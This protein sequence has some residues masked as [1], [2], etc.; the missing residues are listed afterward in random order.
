MENTSNI[1]ASEVNKFSSK[2]NE[3][4]DKTGAFKT[5]HDINPVRLSFINDNYPLKGLCVLDIGCGGGILSEA[6]AQKGA[7]VVGL[8][9]S[10]ENIMI[11]SNHAKENKLDINYIVNTAESFSAEHK[12]QF[13]L[14]TC[15]ELLEHVPD[16]LSIIKSCSE[17]VRPGGHVMLSTINRNLKAYMFGVVAAEYLLGLLPRGTHDYK[18]FILPSELVNWCKQYGLKLNKVNG[19]NYNPLIKHCSLSRSPDINYMIDTIAI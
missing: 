3:W 6:M 18:K 2:A 9:A 19:L 16:P 1:D 7:T 4:W 11:A 14:I 5:L 17:L 10:E 12:H 13:D 15:M 8:D